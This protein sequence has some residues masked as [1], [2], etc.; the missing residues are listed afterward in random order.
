MKEGRKE[1]RN[2]GSEGGREG[3]RE[4]GFYSGP[5]MSTPRRVMMAPPV[6]AA[7]A[8]PQQQ[9]RG[10]FD[11]GFLYTASYATSREPSREL[12]DFAQ[13]YQVPDKTV[14]V[15]IENGTHARLDIAYPNPKTN[16]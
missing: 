12:Y 2:E 15:L 1:G 8:P 4:K 10:M 13:R 5:A 3:G 14:K 11:D 6:M 16:S 9:A 7:P